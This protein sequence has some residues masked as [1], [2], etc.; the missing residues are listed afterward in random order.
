MQF[1]HDLYSL[2]NAEKILGHE[3]IWTQSHT[4]GTA[5]V[6][7]TI[8]RYG[9]YISRLHACVCLAERLWPWTGNPLEP[10]R[11]GSNPSRNIFFFFFGSSTCAVCGP[12]FWSW[13]AHALFRKIWDGIWSDINHLY[14]K[15][16]SGAMRWL[17]VV[18][19]NLI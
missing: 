5:K 8:D 3:E 14:S 15:Q 1:R 18:C 12:W 17:R 7:Y 16:V 4:R 6:T 19:W 13:F 2:K 9:S 10:Y 11:A